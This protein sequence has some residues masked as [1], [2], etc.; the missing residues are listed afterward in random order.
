MGET[1]IIIILIVFNLFFIL[2]IAGIITFIKQYKIKK[3]EHEVK[4]QNQKR[5]HQQELLTTQ[6]EIQTQTMQYIGREIHDN[7]GQK[8]TLASLYTQQL[9]YENKAPH[10]NE[11]IENISSIINDS[12]SELRQLSK[13]LTDDSIENNTISELIE[14]ECSKVNDLK[15]CA[16]HFTYSSEIDISFYQTKSILLRITQEFLQNSIKHS[17]C[18]NIIVTLKKTENQVILILEDDGK[19][20]NIEQLKSSGIGLHNMKKRTEILNGNYL[21]E[22]NPKTGTKLIIEIPLLK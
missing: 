1:E 4:L 3:K 20:F 14:N 15:K 13:S 7:I 19:G 6:L 21:L 2:F 12:L 9:A 11:N 8:L 5:E 10:I 16:V 22:S 18:K 17:Q